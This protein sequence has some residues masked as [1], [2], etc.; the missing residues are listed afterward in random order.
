MISWNKLRMPKSIGGLGLRKTEAF[1]KTF[2]CK[3]VW[4]VFPGAPNLWV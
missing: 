2:R 4:K 3:L 1:N